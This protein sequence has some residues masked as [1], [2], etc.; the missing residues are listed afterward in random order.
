MLRQAVKARI[1]GFDAVRF[2][3]KVDSDNAPRAAEGKTPRLQYPLNK[4]YTLSKEYT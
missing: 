4:E 2:L 1:F 3:P